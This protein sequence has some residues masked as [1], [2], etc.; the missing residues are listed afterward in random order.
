MKRL[1][2]VPLGFMGR[3]EID[4]AIAWFL[5]W[6]IDNNHELG[7]WIDVGGDLKR[8]LEATKTNGSFF[9]NFGTP[10]INGPLRDGFVEK[11]STGQF[12][13]TEKT[14]KRI[15]QYFKNK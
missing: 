9:G 13:M 3:S 2:T 7:D 8:E 15:H 11:A 12:R 5:N 6:H 1:D 10:R 14:I 4:K